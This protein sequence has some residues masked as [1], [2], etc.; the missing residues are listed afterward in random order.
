M[1]EDYSKPLKPL[2]RMGKCINREGSAP[3]GRLQ[4]IIY[5]AHLLERKIN[6]RDETGD[7]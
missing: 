5:D 3:R 7:S 1:G 6:Q 4:Y 2:V